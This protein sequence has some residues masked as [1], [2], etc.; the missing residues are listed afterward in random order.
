M[1]MPIYRKARAAPRRV[2]KRVMGRAFRARAD[3]L[4]NMHA[5]V[6]CKN[7]GNYLVN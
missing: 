1:R 2:G 3:M 7:L 5:D 4:E 6:A